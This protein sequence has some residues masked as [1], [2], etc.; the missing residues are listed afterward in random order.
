MK[1][2]EIEDPE[3]LRF[4]DFLTNVQMAS[5][6]TQ[7]SYRGDLALLGSFCKGLG[8]TPIQM[9]EPDARQF[10]R[11]L[12]GK[13]YSE[14]TV[15]R[16]I[17]ATRSFFAHA[18]KSR[19]CMVNPFGLISLRKAQNHLPSVLTVGEV[20]QLLSL[21]YDDFTSTR[22][23]LLFT[24]L[25]DTGCRISEALS[26]NEADID[27]QRQRIPIV[28]KGNKVRYVFFTPRTAR[29]LSY[30]LSLKHERQDRQQVTDARQRA[31]LFCSDAGKQLPMS[32]VGS[33]FHTYKRKLGWQKDFTPH[34]LRHSYATHMLDNGA[35]IR[36]VQELLG[37]SSIS[38]TQIYAHVT[39]K[40]LAGVYVSCHPHGRK[41]N[42]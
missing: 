11:F 28:G 10:V 7:V 37:H 36:L 32:T 8:I 24:L 18:V 33:I 39:Q 27:Y 40:R 12:I 23:Q 17:S 38:T 21:E 1:Q 19:I 30:Y 6:H 42:E 20:V 4:L 16:I 9:A 15:N 5:V 29:L 22:N 26:I 13:D 14:A 41:E 25:Y 35:D 34:V 31:I 2:N 3:I